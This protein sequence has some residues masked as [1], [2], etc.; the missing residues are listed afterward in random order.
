MNKFAICK[1]Y[2]KR[3]RFLFYFFKFKLC[4][5]RLEYCRHGCLV[6]LNGEEVVLLNALTIEVL[7]PYCR[8]GQSAALLLTDK[9]LG[10]VAAVLEGLE[11]LVRCDESG[12]CS[13][14]T[15]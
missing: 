9:E 7:A 3:Q 2:F 6:F 11:S 8:D 12:D 10:K 5:I 14:P 13:A 4:F 15:D 1:L